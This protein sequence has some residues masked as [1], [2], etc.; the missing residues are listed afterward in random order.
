MEN[1]N[2]LQQLNS[3]FREVL[4]NNSISLTEETTAH[5]IDEWD[6]LSNITLITTV[7][8]HFNVKFKL[9]EILKLKNVGE[10]CNL[11]NKKL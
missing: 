1:N 2:L 7:E 4:N 10:L 9:R 6:S 8:K 3:I 11:I 5:D